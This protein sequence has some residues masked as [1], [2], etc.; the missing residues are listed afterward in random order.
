MRLPRGLFLLLISLNCSLHAQ[1]VFKANV[2]FPNMPPPV[3]GTPSATN[4]TFIHPDTGFASNNVYFSPSSGSASTVYFTN[5]GGINWQPLDGAS[6]MGT[7][8][9]EIRNADDNH[10]AYYAKCSQ[11]FC[12]IY[13]SQGTG[14]VSTYIGSSAPGNLSIF[15]APDSGHC[16]WLAGFSNFFLAKYIH[17]TVSMNGLTQPAFNA[18]R[19]LF[20]ADDRHAL[21]LNGN[22]DIYS[23]SDTGQTWSLFYQD[24][25]IVIK[26]FHWNGGTAFHVL[27]ENGLLDI[28]LDSGLNWNRIFLPGFPLLT[29]DLLKTDSLLVIAADS[30]KIFI[31]NNGGQNWVQEYINGPAPMQ[32]IRLNRMDPNTIGAEVKTLSWTSYWQRSLSSSLSESSICRGDIRLYPNPAGSF[33]QLKGLPSHALYSLTLYDAQGRNCFSSRILSTEDDTRIPLDFLSPGFYFINLIPDAGFQKTY[34]CFFIK[35]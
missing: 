18:P 13:R 22:S 4:I 15:S 28:S 16:Y 33:I 26:K 19:Q 11:G 31:S 34:S 25:S 20:F 21:L 9:I 30:G 1:W 7:A 14:P 12:G 8:S 10:A 3:F 23:S 6:G 24:T 5:D 17:G 29:Y 32:R 2:P 35:N 27:A